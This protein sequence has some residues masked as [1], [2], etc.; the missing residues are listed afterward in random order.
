MKTQ[1]KKTFLT[2]LK[3]LVQTQREFSSSFFRE[4]YSV[5]DKKQ[6][7]ELYYKMSSLKKI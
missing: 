6:C 7:I 3:R 1:S 4:M 5:Q 2:N